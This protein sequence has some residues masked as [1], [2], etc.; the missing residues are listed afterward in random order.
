MCADWQSKYFNTPN[1]KTSQLLFFAHCLKLTCHNE[2]YGSA[3]CIL[4]LFR[5]NYVR[6]SLHTTACD[7]E[8]RTLRHSPQAQVLNL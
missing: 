6:A 2:I 5:Y 7:S 3:V 4:K 8:M 1:F